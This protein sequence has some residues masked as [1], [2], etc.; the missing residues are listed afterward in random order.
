MLKTLN[1]DRYRGF[2]SYRLTDLKRVNLVVGKNNC[3]KTSI[4]EAIELLVSGGSVFTLQ[5]SAERRSEFDERYGANVSHVFHGHRCTPG[6]SFNLSSSGSQHSLG[7][8]AV[9]IP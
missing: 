6:A 3:G 4:L 9:G 2:E 7:A 5:S 8:C 1:L